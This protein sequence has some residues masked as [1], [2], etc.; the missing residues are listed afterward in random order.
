[1]H[2]HKRRLIS[3]MIAFGMLF[4]GAAAQEGMIVTGI[5]LQA[6]PNAVGVRWQKPASGS[7][8]RYKIYYAKESILQNNGRFLDAEETVNDQ[9][10]IALLDLQ[11]RGFHA[12]DTM[13]VTV[14]AID[15]EGNEH[16][17]FGEEKSIA[18][19]LPAGETT[20][21]AASLALENAI[22]EGETTIRLVF[23]AP[24]ATPEGHPSSH[25]TIEDESGNAIY[26]LGFLVEGNA[27]L[28]RTSPM[29]VR[30]RY[31]VTVLPT[32]KGADG[33]PIDPSKNSASFVARPSGAESEVPV[34]PASSSASSPATAEP[35]PLQPIEVPASSS[36]AESSVSSVPMPEPQPIPVPDT[37]PPEDA[38][39]LVLRR[40]LQPDGKYTV[41]ATWEKSIDTAKD[42]ASY[43][44][45]ESDDKGATFAGPT[46]ILGTVVSSAIANIPPGTFTLKV[47]AIDGTGNES[48]GI[49]ETIIL[50]ETGASTLLLSAAGAAVVSARR[51]RR[52]VRERR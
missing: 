50:P 33:S 25:F 36:S 1:M 24:V 52:R 47:T 29:T 28:L 20:H 44:L 34:L 3:T 23:T 40:I 45:Y 37:T 18:V 5:E 21:A 6:A 46:V 51:I 8:S 15:A 14:T 19:I 32:V 30:S 48:R 4:P 42:L 38:T 43:K 13:V 2:K 27:L 12:G 17:A 26:V 11:N 41:K 16:R 39:N 10:S 49:M 35:T 22:A 7:P 9:T 31:T